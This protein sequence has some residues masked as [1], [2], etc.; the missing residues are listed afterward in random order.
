MTNHV[1]QVVA[2]PVAQAELAID[3]FH[4]DHSPVN[5]DPKINRANREQVRRDVVGMQNDKREEQGE[6]NRQRDD[7]R[8]SGA[9]QE[10]DE[11]DQNQDHSAGE[12]PLHRIRGQADQLAA[13]VKGADLDVGRKNLTIELV[14]LRLHGLEHHLGLLAAAHQDD[15]LDGILVVF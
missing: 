4:H 1:A 2:L 7:D 3:V 15:A 12:V 14:G 9:D 8:S 10:K 5:D 13:V 11:D 6:R